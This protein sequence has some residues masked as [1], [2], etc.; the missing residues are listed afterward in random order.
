MQGK[1]IVRP[2]DRMLAGVA[3]GLA[4]YF[5]IDPVLVRL[6]FIVLALI[7][8]VGVLLYLAL[9]LLLPGEASIATDTRG[10]VQ[11]NLQEMQAA[12]ERFLQRL[13]EVIEQFVDQVRG[14]S[15]RP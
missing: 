11:E 12:A 7:N 5:N 14:T 1:R 2:H 4:A 13:R 15:Q 8:G 3:G 9:W 10:Q 6:G